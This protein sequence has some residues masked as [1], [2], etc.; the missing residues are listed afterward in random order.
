MTH[1]GVTSGTALLCSSG[2]VVLYSKW[3]VRTA[4]PWLFYNQLYFGLEADTCSLGYG[5]GNP[6]VLN[7]PECRVVLPYPSLSR[8]KN[9]VMRDRVPTGPDRHIDIATV[10]VRVIV[11]ACCG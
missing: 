7:D 4:W 8:L 1:G 6:I 9:F 2:L 3:L 5:G 10:G 11:V